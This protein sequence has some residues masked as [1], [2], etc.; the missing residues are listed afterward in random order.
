MNPHDSDVT[1]GRG[2]PYRELVEDAPKA[3]TSDRMGAAEELAAHI[4]ICTLISYLFGCL[5]FGPAWHKA[6]GNLAGGAT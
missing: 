2:H 4:M 6:L 5:A 3:R 1:R